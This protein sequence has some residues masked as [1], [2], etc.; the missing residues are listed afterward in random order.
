MSS[1]ISSFPALRRA[2][3]AERWHGVVQPRRRAG[4]GTADHGL[5]DQPRATIGRRTSDEQRARTRGT[6][7]MARTA[8]ACASPGGSHDA[9]T[10][11]LRLCAIRGSLRLDF[12]SW[13]KTIGRRPVAFARSTWAASCA[14]I[15]AVRSTGSAAVIA[16]PDRWVTAQTVEVGTPTPAECWSRELHRPP[17]VEAKRAH[18]T[19]G[20]RD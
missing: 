8:R 18:R 10:S 1:S 13:T 4:V 15:V 5:A 14:L 19:P 12:R 20:P 11:H 3:V 6:R 9:A 17:G 7:A 2:P 16:A